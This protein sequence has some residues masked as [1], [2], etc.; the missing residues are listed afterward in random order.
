LSRKSGNW[1][2]GEKFKMRK[3]IVKGKEAGAFLAKVTA[4]TIRPLAVGQGAAGALLTGQAKILA[5]FDCLRMGEAEF[6]LMSPV[7]CYEGLAQGLEKLHFSEDLLIEKTEEY[8]RPEKK[9]VL[10]NREKIFSASQP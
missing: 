2:Q 6:W 5:Q 9:A 8:F 3:L 7:D 4:G 10:S 1:S